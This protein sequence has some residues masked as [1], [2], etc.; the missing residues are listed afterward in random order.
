MSNKT[1]PFYRYEA[2]ENTLSSIVIAL[3]NEYKNPSNDFDKFSN[4]LLSNNIFNNSIPV[5]DVFLFINYLNEK[6]L[7][8]ALKKYFEDEIENLINAKVD[9]VKLFNDC[10]EANLHRTPSVEAYSM[11]QVA[12]LLNVTTQTIH[13]LIK[14]GEINSFLV[15]SRYRILARD[16]NYFIQKSKKRKNIVQKPVIENAPQKPPVAQKEVKVENNPK[17]PQKA[18]NTPQN[19]P[20]K[21]KQIPQ[22]SEQKTHFK[23]KKENVKKQQTSTLPY[24]TLPSSNETKLVNLKKEEPKKIKTI[25]KPINLPDI[26][27]GEEVE[28]NNVEVNVENNNENVIEEV[29]KNTPVIEEN[30]VIEEKE[31][32]IENN[33]DNKEVKE[34]KTDDIFGEVKT[35]EELSSSLNTDIPDIE[36]GKSQKEK[37]EEIINEEVIN[38]EPEVIEEQENTVTTTDF[39]I[40]NPEDVKRNTNNKEEVKE[41]VSI[42]E[43]MKQKVENLP[44]PNTLDINETQLEKDGETTTLNDPTVPYPTLPN[45]EKNENSDI[46]DAEIQDENKETTKTKKLK[47][48]YLN[49]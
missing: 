13:A 9:L 25:E 44:N 7:P 5:I 49:K 4:N 45:D 16:V 27:M 34:E 23:E 31:E 20:Q 36:L 33:E 38:E 48:N 43:K 2:N 47:I 8:V 40:V 30:T 17:P 1:T 14:T 41:E 6:S 21:K 39:I 46:I 29:V 12:S 37:K 42:E 15:G 18:Q 32:K 11:K 19:Q 26:T 35:K 28:N 10:I 3:Y 22:N 24:H